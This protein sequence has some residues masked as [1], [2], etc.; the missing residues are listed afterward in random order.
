MQGIT[1]R[2]GEQYSL[3]KKKI[4][5]GGPRRSPRSPTQD[6]KI[7]SNNCKLE[8]LNNYFR[9]NRQVDDNMK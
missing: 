3:Q 7:L 4:I 6:L 2:P 5:Q 9:D 1:D 8:T